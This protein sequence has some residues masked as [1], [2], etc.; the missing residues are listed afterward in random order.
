MIL[1]SWRLGRRQIAPQ[2]QVNL[3]IIVHQAF[4][5]NQTR[6]WYLAVK[7]TLAGWK[8]FLK[9]LMDHLV[10]QVCVKGADSP[11]RWLEPW[12]RLEAHTH[13]SSHG[14]LTPKISLQW[15]PHWD[16]TSPTALNVYY[17]SFAKQPQHLS[18]LY[19]ANDSWELSD[20]QDSLQLF[21][22]IQV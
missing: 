21:T 4:F 13:L 11:C 2:G 19:S 15:S 18:G 10:P 12:W 9:I 3:L 5:L 1:F 8:I 6:I 20:S 14:T 7:L 17:C 22:H 16:W